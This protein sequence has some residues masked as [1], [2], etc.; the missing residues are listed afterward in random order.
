MSVYFVQSREGFVK[1]GRSR[2]PE[3]RFRAL[4]CGNPGAVLLG[5]RE[6]LSE[7][8]LHARFASSRESGEWFRPSAE[9]LALAVEPGGIG[10]AEPE[11]ALL[12]ALRQVGIRQRTVAGHLGIS[13]SAFS[14]Q[15]RKPHRMNISTAFA[16]VDLLSVKSGTP[17]TIEEL[18]GS[19]A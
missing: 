12:R 16:I 10:R 6:D 17:W 7:S 9:L 19:A 3:K 15:I 13:E 14:R 4:R 2:T 18:L 1:I 8:D 5:V 11:N